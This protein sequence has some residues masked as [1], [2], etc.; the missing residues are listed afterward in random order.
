MDDRERFDEREETRAAV[1][2]EAAR[3]VS[4][5]RR[6]G[7][8]SPTEGTDETEGDGALAKMG[9]QFERSVARLMR[10]AD[11]SFEYLVSEIGSPLDA[12]IGAV[13]RYDFRSGGWMAFLRKRLQWM[14][15]H[16]RERASRK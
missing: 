9:E 15:M 11:A 5:L 12:V 10:S 4:E 6:H 16:E 13:E 14:A 7:V 3:V 2:V 8:F 1:L